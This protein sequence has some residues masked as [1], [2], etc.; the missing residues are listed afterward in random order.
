MTISMAINRNFFFSAALAFAFLPADAQRTITQYLSGTDKDHTVAWDFYCTTGRRS[1]KWDKI[2]VPS[3][4]ELQGFGTY[5]YFTDTEN[6]EEQGWY[7]H[8]FPIAKARQKSRVFIVFEGS[9]TDTEVKING[10]E[11]GPVHRGGYYRFKYDITELV[12][13]GDNLL[14]VKVSKRSANASVNVA[15]RHADFWQFGGIFRPVYLEI[16]PQTH[17]DRVAIDARADGSIRLDVYA[18]GAGMQNRII[19]GLQTLGGQKIGE[20]MTVVV[21]SGRIPESLGEPITL[22]GRFQGIIPWNPE[23]PQLYNLVVSVTDGNGKPIHTVIQRIGFRTMELRRQDG[24]YVNGKRVLFKGTC[25]HSEW[26]ESGRT[27]SK[28]ISILDVN[29]MK[30]MN[31]NA[32]RMSHYPPDQHFLDVCDSLGLFVLDEL[33]GWQAKYDTVIGKM[34]VKELV[35]RDVNHPSI[36]LWDNGNEGGWNN[37]LNDDFA[38]YDPQKR[39]VI[40]PWADFRGLETE[41][42]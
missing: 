31:I 21:R 34:L 25:R 1:G 18:A 7:R 10:Q 30:D 36:V 33:T 38:K 11:A 24:I 29:L 13:N 6:P 22:R 19:A 35:V 32:V 26:P 9:M 16:V 17:I 12:K 14:E 27:L 23:F 41:H 15:E 5:N 28:D 8:V 20:L 3:N 40:H 4:W 37:D 42:Y 2:A 39:N